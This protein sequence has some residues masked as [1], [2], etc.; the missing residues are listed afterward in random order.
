MKPV[1]YA[2]LRSALTAGLTASASAAMLAQRRERLGRQ[3]E[4]LSAAE[5][6]S[7]ELHLGGARHALL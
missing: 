4:R 2:S 5:H 3:R 6:R 7:D 1:V